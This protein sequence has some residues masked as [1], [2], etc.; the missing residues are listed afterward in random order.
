MEPVGALWVNLIRMVVVPL[1]AASVIGGVARLGGAGRL[2]RL[3]LVSIGI[4]LALGLTGILAGL[5]LAHVGLPLAPLSAEQ[6]AALRAAAASG[7]GELGRTAGRVPGVA[8][9]LGGLVPA[10]PVRA[11]SDGALLPLLV[12]SVLFGSAAAAVPEAQRRAIGDLAEAVVAALVRLIGWVMALAP[13][14]VACLAAPVAARLGW[15][16]LSSFGVF[17]VLVIAGFLA[18]TV[19]VFGA[20]VRYGARMGVGAFARAIAPA[21]AVGFSTTSSMASLPAMIEVAEEKLAVP[22]ALAGFVL[23]L[24]ATLN[25]PGSALYQAVAVV[26][27]AQLYGVHLGAAQY[28]AITVTLLPMTLSVYAGPGGSLLA[29]A[30]ALAAVGLPLEGIGLLFGVDRLPDFFRSATN[31]AGHLTVTAVV[32]RGASAETA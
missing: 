28:A 30:P 5:A 26:F 17:V 11:A 27:L 16:M 21:Y 18:F 29:M 10:N 9:F 3:G 13:L 15:A 22:P 24:A 4:F 32:A 1:V 14:G 20:L 8:E 7:A 12:F 25:R 19:V 6:T 2:G 31:V 23:P